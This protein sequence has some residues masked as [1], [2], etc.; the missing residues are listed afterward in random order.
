MDFCLFFLMNRET[1][2]RKKRVADPVN[3]FIISPYLLYAG[4]PC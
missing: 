3:V 4:R 1:G 2:E